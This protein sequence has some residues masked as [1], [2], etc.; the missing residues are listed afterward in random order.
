MIEW[1]CG[2]PTRKGRPC[3]VPVVERGRP[4]PTHD[5]NGAYA[6]AN[7]TYRAALLA[8]DARP[9]PD[10]EIWAWC[11]LRCALCKAPVPFRE[12][13]RGMSNPLGG[14]PLYGHVTC[15]LDAMQLRGGGA[16]A[17]RP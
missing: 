15:V 16:V 2:M 3:P 4:C 10:A 12:P 7:P 14:K 6:R 11:E 9:D 13:I 5:P 1:P 17:A 8:S